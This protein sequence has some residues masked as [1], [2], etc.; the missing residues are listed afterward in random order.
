VSWTTRYVGK[1]AL[2]SRDP[3]VA[4]QSESLSIPFTEPT[5]YHDVAV[6]YR[7]SGRM[8]GTELFAGV[9]NLFDERPPFTVTNTGQ[10]TAFDL[11]RFLY[12]GV[13]YRR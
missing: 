5:F 11:G 9:Q 12:V 1:M 2:F 3:G 6:R 4:D 7:M 10:G 13:H 8:Q